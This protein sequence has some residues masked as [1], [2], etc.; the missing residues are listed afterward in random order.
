MLDQEVAR[1]PE[2]TSK[3]PTT[4]GPPDLA[5]PG[6]D[7]MADAMGNAFMA[8]QVAGG[9]CDYTVEEGDNLWDIARRQLGDGTRW[10]DIYRDN[11][12]VIGDNPDLI[13]PDQQL[14]L[15]GEEEAEAAEAVLEEESPSPEEQ[16]AAAETAR[17]G[18]QEQLDGLQHLSP[19][20][21][22]LVQSRVQ[23][24]E[25]EALVREMAL[26]SHA[27]ASPNPDRALGAYGEIQRIIEEDP[28]NAARLN[29]DVIE[30]MVN[31]VANERTDSDRGQEGILG[32]TQVRDAARGLLNMNDDQYTAMTD[33]LRDAGLDEDGNPIAGADAGAEQALLL[34]AVGARRDRL[35]GHWYDGVVRFFGGTP[36]SDTALSEITGFADD[37]RG[38][39]REELIRTT[40]LQDIDDENTSDFDPDDPLDHSDTRVNND[41]HFQRYDM[42]CAP[43][44][45]QIL[46][47]EADPIF[48][49][50][51][52]DEGVTN[53]ENGTMAADQQANELAN[54]GGVAV[55]RLGQA[56]STHYNDTATNLE[57][58]GTITSDERTAL[59]K[60]LAGQPLD[61]AEQAAADRALEQVRAAGEDHPTDAEIEAIQSNQGKAGS[62]MM[63]DTA[64]NDVTSDATHMQY[65]WQGQLTGAAGLDGLDQRLM[66]GEDVP[67][68]I[69]WA[70]G[71]HA[72]SITDVRFNA[73]GTRMYLVSD[74]WEGDTSWVSQADLLAN[75]VPLG[76][77]VRIWV[78][79]GTHQ[80]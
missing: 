25:G 35:D 7:V 55:S 74:P 47:G 51:I 53:P 64:L 46:R 61:E 76:Q 31:G 38:Q 26:I 77:G 33:T 72:M 27:M 63:Y 10:E 37:I 41:G 6:L 67:F 58:A 21:A 15:C 42:S 13:H 52:H 36:D 48:A 2:I 18:L 29:T 8:T 30:M 9:G 44:S 43:T 68:Q 70:Q 49:R 56:A 24:L 11:A 60:R 20:R 32:V 22:A 59:D 54:N 79:S 71:A 62:G 16:L 65:G 23:G 78:A 73:D 75:K 4:S 40:T 66:D 28:D 17:A 80:D 12:E 39:D 14:D 5:E 19:E 45:S 3:P 1:S 57:L 34:K 50:Q 69:D